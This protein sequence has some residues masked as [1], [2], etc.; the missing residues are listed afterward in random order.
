MTVANI[1]TIGSS[2][3]LLALALG[4][5]RHNLTFHYDK[6]GKLIKKAI[7]DRASRTQAR[8]SF[9]TRGNTAHLWRF[10]VADDIVDS[11]VVRQLWGI[12]RQ[13]DLR[14]EADIIADYQHNITLSFIDFAGEFIWKYLND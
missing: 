1:E 2:E 8:Y 4:K 3:Y 12:P 9:V 10:N 7:A 11:I 5:Q 13:S 6:N 14:L